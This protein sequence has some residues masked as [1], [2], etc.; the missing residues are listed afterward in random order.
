MTD[1]LVPDSPSTVPPDVP[2]TGVV[3][4]GDIGRGV[5]GCLAKA[6]VNLT[7]CDLRPDAVARFADRARVATSP[8]DLA[9]TSRVTVVA[10]VDDDQV[11]S[12][13]AGPGGL[14]GGGRSGDSIVV[15]STIATDT[16]VELAARAAEVGVSLVDCGVSGGP[17]A[18]ADGELVCMVGGE[19]EAVARVGPVLGVIGSEVL[20][21]GS[22]GAGLSAKLARNIVQYG[23]W[24]AAYEGQLLAE[25]AGIDLAM[26][27]QA[28]RASDR[29]IGG[30]STLMFRPTV[31]PLRV[32]VPTEAGLIEPLGA[33]AR[34]AHK[35]LRSALA[36]ADALDIPLP[37]AQL[38]DA[39]CDAIFGVGQTP[40]G[41]DSGVGQT[42]GS[43]R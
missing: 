15:V 30:A 38:T 20:H 17:A 25:A 7:V 40:S 9:G 21:M 31:A 29:R 4:L 16:V 27:A 10:V 28:I 2:P 14:L 18:A 26:L 37:L 43:A 24:L 6:G 39:H 35:D 34:L 22:L 36:L 41:G 11:R 32:D 19:P 42:G 12:V 33:A 23:S 8:A 13:V 1:Q 3:G 5:A